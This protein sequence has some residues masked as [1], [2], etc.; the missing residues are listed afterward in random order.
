LLLIR[1]TT[2]VSS[3]NLM[4]VFAVPCCVVVGEQGVQEVTEHAPLR[5]SS[6]EDQRGRCVATYRHQL[7]AALQE[8]LSH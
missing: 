2:V 5:D 4:M 6:V 7:G 1:P 8:V 3:A